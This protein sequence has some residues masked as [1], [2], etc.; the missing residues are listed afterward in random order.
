MP[1]YHLR[2]VVARLADDIWITSRLRGEAWVNGAD[3][4][5]ARA[6]ASGHFQDATQTVPGAAS[7]RSPWLDAA[8]VEAD[9]LDAAPDGMTIP[10]GTVV[11]TNQA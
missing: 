5:D 7:P 4:A 11:F 3:E 10:A 6:L 9:K 1:I 2:P 8:F